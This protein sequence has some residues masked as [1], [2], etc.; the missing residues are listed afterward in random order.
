MTHHE[1]MQAM[2][3]RFARRTY[4]RLTIARRHPRLFAAMNHAGA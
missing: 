3:I 1:T 4:N 2:Y